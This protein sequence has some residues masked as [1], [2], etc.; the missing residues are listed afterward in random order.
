MIKDTFCNF[1]SEEFIAIALFIFEIPVAI[2]LDIITLTWVI[3]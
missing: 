3:F 2:K 1:N